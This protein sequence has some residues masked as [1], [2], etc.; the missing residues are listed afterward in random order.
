MER[1]QTAIHALHVWHETW[2]VDIAPV[3]QRLRHRELGVDIDRLQV[4]RGSEEVGE[5]RK[6]EDTAGE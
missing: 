3:D 5:Q 2:D 4:A 1:V 6:H